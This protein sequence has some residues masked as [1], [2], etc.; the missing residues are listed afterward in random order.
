MLGMFRILDGVDRILFQKE[1]SAIPVENIG[2]LLTTKG[3][4][5]P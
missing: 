4:I 5:T 3:L 2:R 1:I